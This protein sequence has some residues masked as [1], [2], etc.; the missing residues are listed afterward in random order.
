M[1]EHEH[2]DIPVDGINFSN[3]KVEH[4]FVLKSDLVSKNTLEKVMPDSLKKFFDGAPEGAKDRIM[5]VLEEMKTKHGSV[6]NYVS[7]MVTKD[8]E[9]I[10]RAYHSQ[11]NEKVEK[12]GTNKTHRTKG[13]NG[14]VLVQ[15]SEHE[16]MPEDMIRSQVEL[17]E[18]MSSLRAELGD[19]NGELVFAKGFDGPNSM[20]E[21]IE[22]VGEDVANALYPAAPAPEAVE[23]P[24]T[25]EA[26]EAAKMTP[27]KRADLVAKFGEKAIAGLEKRI[28]DK[29]A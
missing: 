9:G 6:N 22:A 13:L 12:E 16:C 8:N 3:E 17:N 1:D 14:L 20:Q 23:S 10:V 18:K 11:A 15:S 2:P 21:F 26:I 27:K 4:V 25:K 5:S 19:W 7:Y 29:K 28:K 24:I